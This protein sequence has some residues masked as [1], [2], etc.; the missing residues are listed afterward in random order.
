MTDQEIRLIETI[1]VCSILLVS[2]FVYIL[3]ST[4]PKKSFF[5][6]WVT[7]SNGLVLRPVLP[8][9]S[10]QSYLMTLGVQNTMGCIEYCRLTTKFQS[11]PL[12]NVSAAS[13]ELGN[14]RFFL[15]DNETWTK[16]FSFIV[17]STT[18]GDMIRIHGIG[19]DDSYFSINLTSTFDFN[20]NGFFWQFRFELWAFNTSSNNFDFTN[21]WASSPFLNITR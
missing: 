1:F 19:L 11:A 9:S 5:Q 21:T 6:L 16:T 10:N 3:M 15:L 17:N 4:T 2:A 18:E 20:Q 7:D 14:F 8:V 13:A 12:L